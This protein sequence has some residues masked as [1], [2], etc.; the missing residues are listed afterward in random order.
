MIRVCRI[1][2]F[3]VLRD[4]RYE[5]GLNHADVAK[6]LPI[7][8]SRRTIGHIADGGEPNHYRGEALLAL[9]RAR[10]DR[11][12]PR[13]DPKGKKLPHGSGILRASDPSPDH[14]GHEHEQTQQGNA[15]RTGGSSGI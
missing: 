6:A 7:N 2:W 15:T 4:L 1:D 14:G 10:L 11:E 12:P 9:Y 5:A 13:L 3:A 8:C